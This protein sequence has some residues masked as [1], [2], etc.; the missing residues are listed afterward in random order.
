M[1][2]AFKDVSIDASIDVSVDAFNDAF[3]IASTGACGGALK[4]GKTI[5]ETIP[6]LYRRTR[7]ALRLE[8]SGLY[9]S[10]MNTNPPN[11]T[12]TSNTPSICVAIAPAVGLDDAQAG[13]GA[14]AYPIQHHSRSE[15]VTVRGLRYH[16]RRWG[17]PAGEGAQ[18]LWLLHGWMDVSASYQ[19]LADCLLAH[20]P[21][22]TL[23]APD[24]RGFGLTETPAHCDAYWFADY[25]ADLD[26][27][28]KHYH[29]EQAV[30]VVAHSMGGNVAMLYAGARAARIKHLVNLDGIGLSD[31][32]PAKA[33]SR[34]AKWLDELQTPE[35]FAPYAQVD[36][37]VA[38]LQKNNPRLPLDKAQFLAPHWSAL[39]AD[40]CWHIQGDPAHK[41]SNPIMY[42]K[43]EVLA[44]W[45]AITAPVL[46]VEPSNLGTRTWLKI[47]DMP[48]RLASIAKLQHLLV[49]DAGHML[50]HD[51]P[52]VLAD[53]IR[54]F[55][56]S[57]RLI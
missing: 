31:S 17:K 5:N 47:D 43:A 26:A 33:P 9:N 57:V 45:A 40:G 35:G 13:A 3:N 44:C 2:A 24:W 14:G 48:A 49:D 29:G 32:D 38:R 30:D 28:L 53:A 51:Q 6:I 52:Q 22:L 55:F 56:T 25:L 20:N 10:T 37:V 27:L 41:R 16:V 42:R 18:P 15:F 1:V 54:V 36:G 23:Y 50:H 19:F 12:N 11:R 8:G 7:P 21:N 46:L 39:G 34:Y 4:G